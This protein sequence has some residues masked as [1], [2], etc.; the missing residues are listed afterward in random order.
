MARPDRK[1]YQNKYNDLVDTLRDEIARGMYRPGSY[2][3]GENHLIERFQLS[4]HSVRLA[5]D[6]LVKEGRIERIP[7]VGTRV[8]ARPSER[9]ELFFGVYPS[10]P[11]ETDLTR[12]LEIFHDIHP[13]ITVN[14]LDLPYGNAESIMK[15]LQLGVVDIVTLNTPDFIYFCEN[16][17]L[18]LLE[19]QERR[20]ENYPFLNEFFGTDNGEVY[21]Q[22][23]VYSPIVICYNKNHLRQKGLF[24]PDSGWTWN[25]L[26]QL[27]RELKEPNRF[28]IFFNADHLNRWSIFLLQ[29]GMRFVRDSDGRI[30]PSEPNAFELLRFVRDMIHEN[31][32]FPGAVFGE[33]DVESLFLQ[34]KV[35]VIM[36]TYFR[37]N[38]LKR[39]EF[40]FDIAQLPRGNRNDTLLLSSGT[41][42]NANTSKKEAAQSLADF[43]SSDNAQTLIRKH[44]FSIP[45]NKIIHDAHLPVCPATPSRILLHREMISNYTTYDKLGLTIKECYVFGN[46]LKQYFSNIV[47]EVG[48][49]KLFNDHIQ[50][51]K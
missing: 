3:P 16:G 27:L 20:G 47:D 28:S 32:L 37:L 1:T 13:H 12:L 19:R 11:E 44:T 35:S 39:A 29:Q 5:L 17:S 6:E 14:T 10:M 24:E 2:L 8:A 18:Q 25:D 22:P 33:K 23:F 36:T 9:T 48:L 26:R 31:G 51:K 15:L 34:Q 21:A 40:D 4:K 50:T 7:R 45:A 43:L 38:A 42:V 41:A 46:C 30:A 49:M